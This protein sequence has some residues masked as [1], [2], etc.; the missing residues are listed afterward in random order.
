MA[1]LSI[2]APVGDKDRITKP[3]K[4]EKFKPVA[5]KP[6]DVE[7]VQL[8]LDANG[9]PT[10]ITGKVNAATIKNIRA[11]Q[12]SACGFKK[13]DGI[14]DPGGKTWK[15]GYA[16]LKARHDANMKE[17]ANRYVV[18]EGGKEKYVTKAEFEKR[19]A[20]ALRKVAAKAQMMLGQAECWMDFC[21]DAEATMQ[22]ADGVM[23]QLAEFTVRWRNSK[24]EPP[25]T[26]LLNA[27]SEASLLKAFASKSKPDWKKIMEQEKK[28]VKAYNAGV[29]AFQGYIDARIN[30]AGSIVGKLTLVQD[31]SFAIVEAYMTAQ[32]V[33]QSKGKLSPAKANAL[34]AAT[35]EGIKTGAGEFGSYLAGNDVKFSSSMKKVL[36]NSAFAGAAGF[37]GGALSSKMQAKFVTGWAAQ[38]PAKLDMKY[39]P[40]EA[41]EKYL[42][43]F[44]KSGGGQAF[45]ENLAKETFL[46]SKT[47]FEKGTLTQKDFTDAM[48]KAGTAGLLKGGLGSAISGISK[49]SPLV[50]EATLAR[51]IKASY[52]KVPPTDL[53]KLYDERTLTMLVLRNGDTMALNA[54][55]K[56]SGKFL[57]GL[58]LNVFN[59]TKG[60]ENAK[61]LEKMLEAE[62]RKSA[63]LQKELKIIVEAQLRKDAEKQSK[64][65]K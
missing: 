39:I 32:L 19:Q 56:L 5:N 63:A 11:F 24:A 64:G 43:A 47:A 37:I 45:L 35:C 23:M 48:L 3:E 15:A 52:G 18:K 40:K 34:A 1:D 60:T 54:A 46:L 20:E 9:F 41:L 6:A 14:V 36:L 58:V 12:K 30:T 38:L 53:L 27:R 55:E 4:N 59:G 33:V 44:L 25:Y 61:Q 62:I 22:G 7:I 8:M 31:T 57:E 17:L 49:R 16:K 42:T 2:S 26:P 29:K 13:P 10:L 50:L 28:A 65:K 51:I 21:K